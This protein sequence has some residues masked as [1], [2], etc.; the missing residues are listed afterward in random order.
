[1]ELPSNSDWWSAI[2]EMTGQIS[3]FEAVCSSSKDGQSNW[4]QNKILDNHGREQAGM[5]EFGYV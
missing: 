4:T 2:L 3:P 1:M 5:P